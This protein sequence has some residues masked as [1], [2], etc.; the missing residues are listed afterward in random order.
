MKMN[1]STMP[2]WMR[3]HVHEY[4]SSNGARGHIWNGIPTLLL[5]T[6]GRR[7]GES[8]LIP[9]IYGKYEKAY[10]VV[11][12]KGGSPS[13]PSWYL[14]LDN[15]SAV[16]VQVGEQKFDA[17]ARTSNGE[18]RAQLWEIMCGV[19]PTYSEYQSKTDREIPVVV[20]DPID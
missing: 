17:K 9:L 7:T 18:E 12:S 14:N 6:T 5:T 16:Q 8:R 2:R 10:V 13:H 19:F 11:A 1:D 15:Q 20:L 3:E 4:L